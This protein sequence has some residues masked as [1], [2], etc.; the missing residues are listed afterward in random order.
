MIFLNV[1]KE[2]NF[3]CNWETE[4]NMCITPSS[5]INMESG[6]ADFFKPTLNSIVNRCR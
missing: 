2:P 4:L 5:V 3:R 1:V 6:F